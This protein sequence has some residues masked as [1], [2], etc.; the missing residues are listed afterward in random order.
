[1]KCADTEEHIPHFIYFTGV[2]GSGKTTIVSLL[3]EEFEKRGLRTKRVWLR[4]NYLFTKPVLLFCRITGLT[5]R[6]LRGGKKISVHDFY[7]S[8]FIGKSVQYLHLLDTCIHF[9]F[10]VYLPMKIKK[11]HILCDRFVYDILADFMVENR[12]LTLPNKQIAKLLHMLIPADAMVFNV[13]VDKDEIIRRKPE[14]LNDDEDYDLK[15]EAYRALEEY[16]KAD[17]INNNKD[18]PFVFQEVV[19]KLFSGEYRCKSLS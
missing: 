18:N 14:V 13:K 7:K 17:V 11:T 2:D 10:R 12:N 3:S 1:M 5:R 19:N 15:Y 9:F 16:I 6:P 4:F 8:P